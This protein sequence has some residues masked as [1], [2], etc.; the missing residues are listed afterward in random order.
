MPYA[1]ALK[2]KEAGFRQDGEG[3]YIPLG[4][5]PYPYDPTLDEL[6]EACGDSFSHLTKARYSQTWTA[7]GHP[8]KDQLFGNGSTAREAVANLWLATRPNHENVIK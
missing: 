2:L 3:T 8:I 4:N 7:Q 5:K 6:I 1:L